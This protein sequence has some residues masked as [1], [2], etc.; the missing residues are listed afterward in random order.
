MSKVIDLIKSKYPQ[1]S[2]M[3]FLAAIAEGKFDRTKVLNSEVVELYRALN[4]REKIQNIYKDKLLEANKKNLV[5][6]D[7]LAVMD[8]VIDDEGETDEHMDHLDMRFKL[9]NGT[10]IKRGYWPKYNEELEKVNNEWVSICKESSIFTLMCCTAAIEGWYP[11]ISEFFEKEY[12]KRGFNNDELELFIAHQGADVEHS[13]AQYQILIDNEKIIDFDE[14]E[15]MVTRTFNTSKEYD[16]IKLLFAN[17]D[18][19]ISSYFEKR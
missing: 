13:E 3:P 6:K 14:V 8:E 16:R 10:E 1:I 19:D 15:K 11:A 17:E 12:L 4:T 18:K 5:S 7:Q 9:F 2:E